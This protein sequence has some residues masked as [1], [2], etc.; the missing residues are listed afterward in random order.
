MTK[1][2]MDRER[3]P[4]ARLMQVSMAD[5]VENPNNPRQHFDAMG[6]DDLKASIEVHGILTPIRARELDRPPHRIVAGHRR[7]RA[8]MAAGL[9]MAP[10][11]LG[12]MTDEQEMEILAVDNLQRV[13]LHPLDEAR[14]FKLLILAGY[15]LARLCARIGK[16]RAFV[17]GRLRL[18]DLSR[19]AQELFLAGRFEVGHAALLSRLTAEEQDRAIREGL[20][21]EDADAPSPQ[22]EVEFG[23]SQPTVPVSVARFDEWIKNHVCLDRASPDLPDLFPET[24]A[25]LADAA[26]RGEETVAVT[27][28]TWVD[29]ALRDGGNRIWPA[30]EWRLADGSSSEALA[31]ENAVLGVVVTGRERGRALRVCIAHTTCDI[32]WAREIRE[33]Q[34]REEMGVTAKS[35][36]RSVGLSAEDRVREQWWLA[37]ET[38]ADRLR[39]AI[40]ADPVTGASPVGRWLTSWLCG[41]ARADRAIPE[42]ARADE[43]V[44][45]VAVADIDDARDGNSSWFQQNAEE[46][47][48]A[49]GIDV[50]DLLA[51]AVPAT[52]KAQRRVRRKGA[53]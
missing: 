19:E 25:A 18:L 17:R 48:A 53:A 51:A 29:F 31:C 15:N 28:S 16:S 44:R 37:R 21:D 46:W 1:R 22:E 33:A 7:Y 40:D 9:D 24:A 30:N 34:V 6:L 4:V 42:A 27:H 3:P 32:H 36:A 2:P 23:D 39:R 20:F 41:A 5:L 38:I 14:G 45:L 12:E 35:R 43:L 8:A 47:C 52:S 50:S 13:D 49:L 10:V 26:A 11:L